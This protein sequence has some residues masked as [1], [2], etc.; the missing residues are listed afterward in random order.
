MDFENGR[1]GH[2][3]STIGLGRSRSNCGTP[4]H[5]KSLAGGLPG[6]LLG[7]PAS[8]DSSKTKRLVSRNGIGSVRLKT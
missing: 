6:L 5:M 8:S 7:L 4:K 3:A 2:G 1:L